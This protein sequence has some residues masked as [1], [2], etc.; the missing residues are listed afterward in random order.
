M[1]EP[2]F[3]KEIDVA[4][5]VLAA[6]PSA[7]QFLNVGHSYLRAKRWL[8]THELLVT[9]TGQDDELRRSFN[10]QYRVDLRGKVRKLS[11]GSEE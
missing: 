2:V 9:L 3:L 6:D 1:Y 7:A 11:Q 5:M 4:K 10:L 8:N